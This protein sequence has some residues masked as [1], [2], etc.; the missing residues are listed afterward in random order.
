MEQSLS[1]DTGIFGLN[2]SFE[3]SELVIIPV[4]WEATAS[5]GGGTSQGPAEILKESS[6]IDLYDFYFK[7]SYQ[8]GIHLIDDLETTTALNLE[9][10]ESSQ[11]VFDDLYKNDKLTIEGEAHLKDVNS[12][13]EK[14]NNFVYEHS[15]KVLEKDK[16]GAVLGG[17]HSS[18]Y[19]L[20]KA[21][22]EKHDEY[23][24]LHIDAHADLRDAYLG[25]E[26]SHASIMDNILKLENPPKKLTQ[27]G[28]R[29]FCKE[30]LASMEKHNV[31]CFFDHQLT[32]AKFKGQ[33]WDK[34]CE[35]IISTLPENVYIS[36][37][38]DG[39]SPEFSPNTG[40]P[41]P[42]GLS[43]NEAVYLMEKLVESGR[44]IIGFDLC[45]VSPK[46]HVTNID[47]IIGYR[48]LYKLCGLSLLI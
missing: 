37:D 28:I 22:S 9:A 29:D 21:L 6:Q 10:K 14:I 2:S 48:V 13:S 43:F 5:Y 8:R 40:T 36:F 23:G 18:P 39:L 24:I 4:C 41:V 19:G 45:E 11:N 47:V 26:H 15:K 12:L 7:E 42:G 3:N 1:S 17:D 16:I 25:F 46:P 27:V 32:E 44:K 33:D 30:E 20:V 35:V 34:T 38:I 31:S